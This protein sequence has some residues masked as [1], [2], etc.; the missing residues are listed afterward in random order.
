MLFQK[1]T[2]ITNW[3]NNLNSDDLFAT[4]IGCTSNKV[5]SLGAHYDFICRLWLSDL[6]SERIKLKSLKF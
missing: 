1:E 5:P 6:S 2:S 4:C 3:V